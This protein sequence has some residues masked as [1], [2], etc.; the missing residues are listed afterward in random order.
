MRKG[1]S[2]VQAR[3]SDRTPGN[4]RRFRMSDV[5]QFLEQYG[6]RI[7]RAAEATQLQTAA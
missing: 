6:D 4:Q 7:D 2:Y 3:R 1:H 5:L